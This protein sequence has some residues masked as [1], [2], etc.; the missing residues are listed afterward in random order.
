RRIGRV[1]QAHGRDAVDV[2]LTTSFG[3]TKLEK[4]LVWTD[5]VKKL[6][7]MVKRPPALFA[8]VALLF[9]AVFVTFW[10]AIHGP[11]IWDDQIN[12]DRN[13]LVRSDSGLLGIWTAAPGTYD[14]YPLTWTAWWLQWRMFARETTG[15]HVV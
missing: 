15:Y 10:P 4:F 8:G 11:F 7:R 1:K 6:Y 9:A 14:Y 3:P 5:E 2:A 13:P 12:I